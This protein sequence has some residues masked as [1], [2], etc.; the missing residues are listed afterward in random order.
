VLAYSTKKSCLGALGFDSLN[1]FTNDDV[2]YTGFTPSKFEITLMGK[3]IQKLNENFFSTEPTSLMISKLHGVYI[4]DVKVF[5][6]LK[7]MSAGSEGMTLG[8]VLKDLERKIL[9]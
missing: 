8:F 9:M 5:S 1:F 2:K 4:A 3:L 6:G 7:M